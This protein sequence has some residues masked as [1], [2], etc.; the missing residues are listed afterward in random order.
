MGRKRKPEEEVKKSVTVS[1]PGRLLNAIQ[2]HGY[3]RSRLIAK[4]LEEYFQ[5]K[6]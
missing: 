1:L 2:Q 6:T 5:K 3:N 4:L